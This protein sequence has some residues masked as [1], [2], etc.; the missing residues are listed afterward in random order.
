M[1]R[2]WI[3]NTHIT[4]I[5]YMKHLRSCCN[6][7]WCSRN[8]GHSVTLG[9]SSH[10]PIFGK[11]VPELSFAIHVIHWLLIICVLPNLPHWRIFDI[12]VSQLWYFACR[13]FSTKT[14]MP[15]IQC[16]MG[17]PGAP[18]QALRPD[19]LSRKC[20]GLHQN[21]VRNCL[22]PFAMKFKGLQC[23]SKLCSTT[24]AT[25]TGLVWYYLLFSG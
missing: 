15:K 1:W 7:Y 2:I 16:W 12:F 21:N 24:T 20:T 11:T 8:F 19:L 25:S 4:Y 22:L 23:F 13:K 3:C 5:T 14:G 6:A 18:V 17:S 10:T 9:S